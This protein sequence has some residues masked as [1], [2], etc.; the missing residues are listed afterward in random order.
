MLSSIS[1]VGE[2][3]RRQRWWLTALAHLA[4]SVTGGTAVG[5]ILGAGGALVAGRLPEQ[6]AWGL[7]AAVAALGAAIDLTARGWRIPSWRR[8]VDERWLTRYRGWVYGAGYGLQLGA[9]AFTI[10]PASAT[11]VAALAAV[12]TGSWAQGAVIGA[13]FGAARA[14]PLLLMV[15]VRTP[16]ALRER[17]R[18]LAGRR[19]RA[20]LLTG[21]GQVVVALMGALVMVGW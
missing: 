8:Q 20:V 15:R 1:P 17:M 2:A 4:G 9:G 10:V 13:T 5:T 7:L 21:T 11:Y 19:G 3:S 6:G 16:E 12:L 18:R 14:L